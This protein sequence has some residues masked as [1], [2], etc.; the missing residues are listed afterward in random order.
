MYIHV[1]YYKNT[2][3][4]IVTDRKRKKIK[5]Q[6]I[7]KSSVKDCLCYL[8]DIGLKR[9]LENSC[10][11]KESNRNG[12]IVIEFGLHPFVATTHVQLATANIW[13]MLNLVRYYDC[14]YILHERV[15]VCIH[16]YQP[17]LHII[18]Y[19]VNYVRSGNMPCR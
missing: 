17:D 16:L 11:S 13:L 6:F 14:M 1:I 5:F 19:V 7:Q 12:N 2:F 8:L 10:S 18:S 4:N 3:F 9:L 15:V